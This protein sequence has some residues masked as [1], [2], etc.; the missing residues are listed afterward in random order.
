MSKITLSL[1]PLMGTRESVLI[2]YFI[3][4]FWSSHYE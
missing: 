4:H 3:S 2:Q 1:V